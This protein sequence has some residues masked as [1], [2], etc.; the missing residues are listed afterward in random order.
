MKQRKSI[1]AAACGLAFAAAGA[2]AQVTTP[3]G[4]PPPEQPHD[5][6]CWPSSGNPDQDYAM[7][8]YHHHKMAAS[9]AQYELDHGTDPALRAI[10]QAEVNAYNAERAQLEGWFTAHNVVYTEPMWRGP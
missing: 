8:I 4:A 6:R 10:A 1:L 5:M 2:H 7:R 3:A 9:I